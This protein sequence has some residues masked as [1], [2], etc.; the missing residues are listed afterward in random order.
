[1]APHNAEQKSNDVMETVNAES[2][3]KAEIATEMD[4]RES[5]PIANWSTVLHMDSAS[6]NTL[7]RAETVEE[8]IK[9]RV[10]NHIKVSC[11]I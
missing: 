9:D 5:S 11:V 6:G 7:R 1:M 2:A 4:N 3:V 8:A 10:P